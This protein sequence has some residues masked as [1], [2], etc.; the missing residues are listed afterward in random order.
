MK[1]LVTASFLIFL[2]GFVFLPD[3]QAAQETDLLLNAMKIE[4]ERSVKAL[5]NAENEPLYYL[6]YALVDENSLYLSANLGSILNT[7]HTHKRYL[8]VDARVGSP[9]L[10]NTHELRGGDHGFDYSRYIPQEV[11]VPLENDIDAIRAAIW[12]ETDKQY[13]DAQERLIKVKANKMV[14]VEEEDTSADFSTAKPVIY[15]D[16]SITLDIDEAIWEKKLKKYSLL[17]KKYPWI[18]NARV[19]LQ[20]EILH[21]YFVN[22]E[23]SRIKEAVPRYRLSAFARTIA[24]DGMELY[25]SRPFDSHT[26]G[27]LPDDVTFIASI[28]EMVRDLDKLRIAPL[29]EPFTGPAILMNKASGV[30]FHEI[31]GHRI[32]GHRQKS[33]K[34]GQTF[35]NKVGEVI[36]PDFISVYDD[37]TMKQLNGQDLN[38]YYKFDDEGIPSQRVTVVEKGILRNFLMSRSPIEG[39]NKSNGHGRRQHG[40]SIVARQGNLIVES[41]KNVSFDKLRQLLI[42]ECQKQDKPYGLIFEDLSGGFTSTQ[43]RSAQVFKVIPLLAR[44]VYTD[45]RDDEIVRG[46]DIVGTPLLSFSK[47]LA[48]A[49]DPLSF[50]GH[51]GAESGSVPVGAISPSILVAEI[52]IEKKYKDQE[53][54]PILSPPT[55]TNQ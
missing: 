9:E 18:Y 50:N 44:K 53:K 33:S 2:V 45:G 20:A 48:T 14:K 26:I 10:D 23:G 16:P 28:E 37:P 21:K 55:Y 12:K 22:S 27:R 43:R 36:L 39:F 15:A 3:C 54:P 7:S 5:K 46:V 42:E 19:T 41:E 49:D 17:F 1:K 29:V 8:R 30:F 11:E 47:I 52:E 13:K 35:T 24:D 25:L 32:E 4:L 6:Q 40:M 31:F 34:E 51:C 38:G